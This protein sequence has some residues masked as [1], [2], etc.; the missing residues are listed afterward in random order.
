MVFATTG[1]QRSIDWLQGDDP[2]CPKWNRGGVESKPFMTW[3]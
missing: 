1:W 2:E 3:L